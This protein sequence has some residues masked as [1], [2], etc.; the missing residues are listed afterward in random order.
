[1]TLQK[2]EYRKRRTHSGELRTPVTF[3]EYKPASGPFPGEKE[4]KSIYDCMA[5]VDSVW[6]KD[7]EQAKTNGTLSDVTLTI[8][9]PMG[10]YYPSNKHYLKIDA[11]EY[12]GYVYNIYSSQPDL[13]YR[14]FINVVAKLKDEMRWE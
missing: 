7:L 6:L 9:D 4:F 14:D 3:Y 10:D 11:P 8:R 2:N 12:E 5:K 1:M 13:Q